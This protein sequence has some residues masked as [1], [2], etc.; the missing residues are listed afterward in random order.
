MLLYLDGLLARYLYRHLVRSSL[1]SFHDSL[2][3]PIYSWRNARYG[4][5]P[6]T[7]RYEFVPLESPF[8][9]TKHAGRLSRHRRRYLPETFRGPGEMIEIY[10]W[11][12]KNPGSITRPEVTDEFA[13]RTL[14]SA[15]TGHSPEGELIGWD[16]GTAIPMQQSELRVLMH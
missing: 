11:G 5:I 15:G 2:G 16:G 12:T 3:Q 10:G 13:G 8:P 6:R 9:E 14:T 1:A 4:S 7:G